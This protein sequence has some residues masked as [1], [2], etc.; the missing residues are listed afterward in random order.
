MKKKI[1]AFAMVVA[2]LAIAVVGGTLAYFTDDDEATN[3]FTVGSIE[4]DL[5]ESN[6]QRVVDNVD[7]ADIKADALTYDTSVDNILPGQQIRK[8]PYVLNTGKNAAYVRVRAIL[9]K[10]EDDCLY[11]ME[12]TTAQEDGSIVV[13]YIFKDAAGNVLVES[14]NYNNA[15]ADFATVEYVYTYTEAIEPG[16]MTYWPAFWQYRIANH[17][18]QE[19]TARFDL[20]KIVVQAEAIQAET[21]ADYVA[22]FA[23]F[24]AQNN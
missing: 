4:I 11:L 23:A 7:D 13:S 12:T 24:D 14:D 9:E 3:T 8:A 15:P 17:L 22:A 16:E 20:D 21:F 18:N 6:Y 1:I 2:M 19:E 5:L 10:D